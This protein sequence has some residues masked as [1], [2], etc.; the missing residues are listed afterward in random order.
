MDFYRI[1]HLAMIIYLKNNTTKE[2]LDSTYSGLIE[3]GFSR[4]ITY[5]LFKKKYAFFMLTNNLNTTNGIK[6]KFSKSK[7]KNTNDLGLLI[8]FYHAIW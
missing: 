4:K 1:K 3:T 6:I 7:F 2:I 8:G 5:S